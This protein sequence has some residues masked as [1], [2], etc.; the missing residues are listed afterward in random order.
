MPGELN[1]V[2]YK[3]HS[4]GKEKGFG[5]CSLQ[6]KSLT[7][8]RTPTTNIPLKINVAHGLPPS[9]IVRVLFFLNMI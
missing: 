1:Q 6:K 7:Q 4:K 5:K 2:G 8:W 3:S 9:K